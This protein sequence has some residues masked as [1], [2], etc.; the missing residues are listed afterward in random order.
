MER[1]HWKEGL[2]AWCGRWK[3]PPHASAAARRRPRRPENVD[4]SRVECRRVLRAAK[5]N[6][7]VY[8]ASRPAAGLAD[9]FWLLTPLG[10]TP[11]AASWSTVAS[12]L[13]TIAPRRRAGYRPPPE[14]VTV[15]RRC[16]ARGRVLRAR[17]TRPSRI[18]SFA[19]PGLPPSLALGRCRSRLSP[20]LPPAQPGLPQGGETVIE[21]PN[22]HLG[23]ALTWFGFARSPRSCSALR[24]HVCD[25]LPSLKRAGSRLISLVR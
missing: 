12:S 14:P 7:L 19:I 1:L 25:L 5:A 17:T 11:A 23:Y 21:F 3:R 6:V 16:A 13:R 24:R 8:T 2:I 20:E 22:N 4:F 18:D 9:G 10:L 15:R